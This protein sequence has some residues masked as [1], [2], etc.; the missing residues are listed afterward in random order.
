MASS[1]CV[2]CGHTDRM[3][4]NT[5]QRRI[6]GMP[7]SRNVYISNSLFNL[8]KMKTKHCVP[9]LYGRYCNLIGS[10]TI[11]VVTP[12]TTHYGSRANQIVW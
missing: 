11:V 2:S 10:T 12:V 3:K 9:K 4:L 5:G 1:L 6:N 8:L 7:V